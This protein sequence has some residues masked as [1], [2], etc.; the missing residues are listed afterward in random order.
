MAWAEKHGNG[1]RVRYRLDDNRLST[2]TGFTTYDQARDRALDIES[3]MRTGKFVDPRAGQT[4]VRNWVLAWSEATDVSESSWAKYDSHLRNHILPRFGDTPLNQISRI[5]VKGWVKKLRRGLADNTVADIVTLFSMILGEAVDEGLIGANPCRK[6]RA[7][8]GDQPERPHATTIQVRTIA[9]QTVRAQDEILIYT[10]AYTGMRWGEIAGLQ[11]PN[12][13]LDNAKLRIHPDHG[14]LHEVNGRVYLGPPKTAASVRIIDLAPCTV[15]ML[16][17]L[18]DSQPDEQRAVFTGADGGWHRRS[19]FRRRVWLPATQGHRTR[20]WVPVIPAMHF[21]DLRHTH[22]TWMIE[23]D[24]PDVL[25]HRRLGHRQHGISG[26]YSHTTQVMAD[27][28][29]AA[30]QRRWEQSGSTIRGDLY[31]T[32][33]GVKIFC[34]QSAPTDAEQPADEDRRRAV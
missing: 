13:D 28:L 7:R 15:A 29:L 16:T 2:E 34:S 30:L 32:T 4:L 5:V 33:K 1:Y 8:T 10:A 11:W 21:H 20:G 17:L 6:L 3:L 27:N 31:R 25:Q 26:V 12:V 14:A 24:T 22:K 19:N 18:R 9:A 23:D